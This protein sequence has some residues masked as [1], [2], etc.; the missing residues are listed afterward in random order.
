M[1]TKDSPGPG[2]LRDCHAA[3]RTCDPNSCFRAKAKSCVMSRA[4][5]HAHW[6]LETFTPAN[7]QASHRAGAGYAAMAVP[8]APSSGANAG[9]QVS[10]R[11]G[12]RVTGTKISSDRKPSR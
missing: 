2:P 12:V 4:L 6:D 3:G 10:I 1:R 11:V 5:Q 7:A 8:V 9:V